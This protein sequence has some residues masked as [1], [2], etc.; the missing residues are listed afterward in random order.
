MASS[1][2]SSYRLSRL[3]R[4]RARSSPPTTSTARAP[5]TSTWPTSVTA[6][7]AAP[8][9][10]TR[11]HSAPRLRPAQP[12]RPHSR[13][14]RSGASSPGRRIT[15]AASAPATTGANS[16]CSNK[17]PPQALG[18]PTSSPAPV[19]LHPCPRPSPPLLLLP[20]R[21][22]LQP[23]PPWSDG[24]PPTLAS[25]PQPNPHIPQHP[26]TCCPGPVH[27][28]HLTPRTTATSLRP[29]PGPQTSHHAW[30]ECTIPCHRLALGC[31]HARVRVLF[32]HGH[33]TSTCQAPRL[34]GSPLPPY[35]S[36]SGCAPP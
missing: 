4:R 8:A 9:G 30:R 24:P 17:L 27:A 34:P 33:H 20:H 6:S 5:E 23:L 26:P 7:A 2:R 31:Y 25:P 15:Q 21:L 18:K 36:T 19:Q 13:P 3:S 29:G 16:P 22:G 1:S 14:S 35:F 32:P 11:P 12:A 10:G 28:S